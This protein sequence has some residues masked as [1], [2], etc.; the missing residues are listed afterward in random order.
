V[1]RFSFHVSCQAQ[2]S[3]FNTQILPVSPSPDLLPSRTELNIPDT[4]KQ[5]KN[6]RI[7]SNGAMTSSTQDD[8]TVTSEA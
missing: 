1:R 4:V 2:L 6:S 5:V 3:L 8:V 7:S